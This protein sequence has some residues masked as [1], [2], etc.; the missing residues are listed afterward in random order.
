M[1]MKDKLYFL[2][3]LILPILVEAQMP[4]NNC[5]KGEN[6]SMMKTIVD[7]GQTRKGG[8]KRSSFPDELQKRFELILDEEYSKSGAAGLSCAVLL[9][10]ELWTGVAGLSS[11]TD[12][13][14]SEMVLGVGSLSKS[15]AAATV[16]KL[17]EEGRLS[18]NDSI[19]KWLSKREYVDGKITIEQLLNH[20]SGIYNVTDNPRF[21][22]MINSDYERVWSPDEVL[23]T[24]LLAPYFTPGNGWHYSNSNYIIIGLI[25]EKVTGKKFHEVVRE[26]L[27]HPYGLDSMYLKPFESNDME[28]AHFWGDPLGGTNSVDLTGFGIDFKALFSGAWAAGAYMARTKDIAKWM[29]LLASGKILKKGS[30]DELLKGVSRGNNAYYGLGVVYVVNAEGDIVAIG[31]DGNIGYTAK[32]YHLV[33]EDMTFAIQ[34]NDM[35]VN[36]N[37]LNNVFVK[38]IS[39]YQA[40]INSVRFPVEQDSILIYPNPSSDKVSFDFSHKVNGNIEIYNDL[41]AR[42]Q[43]VFIDSN[44]K[45]DLGVSLFPKGIYFVKSGHQIVG[46]FVVN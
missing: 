19:G 13:M 12:S 14:N 5:L 42:V 31:H 45:A 32:V 15:I 36:Q 10:D 17:E 37:T 44:G 11:V 34:C 41:G 3:L 4:F 30:Q 6:A 46:K 21:G 24:F 27:L 25:V 1:I 26:K 18:I 33:N 43:S 22:Q 16:L 29:K 8:I 20:T 39:A 7:I 23:D 28:I 38:F 2:L 40:Y 35:T 9:G